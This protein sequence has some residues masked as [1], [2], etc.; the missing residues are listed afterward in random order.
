M[1][2]GTGSSSLLGCATKVWCSLAAKLPFS[3]LLGP[4]SCRDISSIAPGGT[5]T[6]NGGW[7]NGRCRGRNGTC[8]QWAEQAP[9]HLQRED[10]GPSNDFA[11]EKQRWS[12]HVQ[13]AQQKNAANYRPDWKMGCT[14]PVPQF[15]IP[16]HHWHRTPHGNPHVRSQPIFNVLG[17]TFQYTMTKLSSNA[18]SVACLRTPQS[19]TESLWACATINSM[20]LNNLNR[21]P[22]APS[23]LRSIV[24]GHHGWKPYFKG[25]LWHG[26]GFA[27]WLNTIERIPTFNL[28]FKDK[29]G[30]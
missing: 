3:F 8:H 23:L 20:A 19:A 11:K 26:L 4:V 7:R 10:Q 16:H 13:I 6:A 25:C 27:W 18:P 22:R 17:D 28:I 1:L 29:N 2:L 14:C 15:Q 24:N 21:S 9:D 12:K 5:G 30:F